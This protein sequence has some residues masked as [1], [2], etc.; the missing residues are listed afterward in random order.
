MIIFVTSRKWFNRLEIDA[1]KSPGQSGREGDNN[2]LKDAE[3]KRVAEKKKE[4]KHET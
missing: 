1:F 2:A 4:V 3:E